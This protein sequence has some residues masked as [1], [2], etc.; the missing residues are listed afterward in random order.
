MA[1]GVESRP[2]H[3]C[4]AAPI[5]VNRNSWTFPKGTPLSHDVE[6]PLQPEARRELVMKAALL[7]LVHAL[8]VFLM[9][10]LLIT[11]AVNMIGGH[12]LPAI[13]YFLAAIVV[14]LIM[15]YDRVGGKDHQA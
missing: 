1:K 2:L 8:L 6:R 10:I 9:V 11:G 3:A 4:T 15:I 7:R 12:W 5:T 13:T 14:Q